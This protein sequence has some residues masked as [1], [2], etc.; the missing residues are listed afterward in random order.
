M[1]SSTIIDGIIKEVSEDGGAVLVQNIKDA[2]S[3]ELVNLDFVTRIKP[4]PY[5]DKGKRKSI[6]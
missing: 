3:V 6:W 5:N 1:N 4:I 2:E